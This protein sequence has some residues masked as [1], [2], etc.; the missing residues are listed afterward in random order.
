MS[1]APG[2]AVGDVLAEAGRA[3][4]TGIFTVFPWILAAEILAALPVAGG[5]VFNTDLSVLGRPLALGGLLVSALVQ[6]W[7]YAMAIQRLTNNGRAAARAALRAIP[8]LLIAYLIYE[9][10]VL[11]GLGIALILFLP[12]V[13][14]FGVVAGVIVT[15]IPLAPTAWLSTALAFF[16]FPAVLERRG[17]LAALDRSFRLARTRWAHAALVVSVPAGVLLLVAIAQ[18]AL[19]VWHAVQTAQ[20]LMAQLPSQPDLAQMQALLDRVTT[21]P[22]PAAHPLWRALCVL[23]SALAWWYTLAVCHAEYTALTRI[24]GTH[25]TTRLESGS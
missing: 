21:Q 3:F 22:A 16:A 6:T 5:G 18:D 4:R 13:L 1:S 20:H 7:L 24:A 2:S 11:L 25:R 17:P 19:P 10:L 23:L 9:V 14:L 12:T 8:A 15:L